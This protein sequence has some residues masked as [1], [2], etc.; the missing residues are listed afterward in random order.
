MRWL[1]LTL[2]A[3]VA[4]V[5]P[6]LA[7][8]PQN[9]VRRETPA[10]VPELQFADGEG[11]PRT[12]GD[13]RGKVVLLNV[14]ATWCLSCRKEM[15]T[16]DRLQAALGGP[17]FEVVALSVDRGGAEIVRN[18]YTDISIQHLGVHVDSSGKA[19][20]ALAIAGLPTTLLIDRHGQELGRL[21][22]PAEWDA[23]DIVA[24]LKSIIA[25]KEGYLSSPQ[26]KDQPL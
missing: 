12:L 9:F 15:P 8:P 16:L 5:G 10:P 18:F 19:G 24:F 17:D 11:K 23:P 2:V 20:F 4:A 13:F 7:D 6:A 1:A 25:R 3:V 21:V 14:W 22:G 26:Q